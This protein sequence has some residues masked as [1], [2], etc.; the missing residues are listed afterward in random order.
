MCLFCHLPQVVDSCRWVIKVAV[1][2]GQIIVG[3]IGQI[4]VG[5]AD[6]KTAQQAGGLIQ[7]AR[8][9]VVQ[10]PLYGEVVLRRWSFCRL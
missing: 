10:C 6:D 8:M 5:M 4:G 7:L 1:D 2:P 3:L 9:I